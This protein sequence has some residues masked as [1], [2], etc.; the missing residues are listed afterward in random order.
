MRNMVKIFMAR[1]QAQSLRDYLS[2]ASLEGLD[3]EG[4]CKSLED[5]L[6]PSED[7]RRQEAQRICEE[8]DGF[9]CCN[10]DNHHWFIQ[11]IVGC[12]VATI[13]QMNL[14][15][16]IKLYDKNGHNVA[17]VDALLEDEI[18]ASID[19]LGVAYDSQYLWSYLDD[20]ERPG[21]FDNK[22]RSFEGVGLAISFN[23]N[24][25]RLCALL[26]KGYE[27]A[28]YNE[29]NVIFK[30]VA[31]SCAAVIYEDDGEYSIEFLQAFGKEKSGVYLTHVPAISVGYLVDR[32]PRYM[33]PDGC[34]M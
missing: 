34:V 23:R 16:T 8:V 7:R 18:P 30:E 17:V 25:N 3:V 10:D 26:G 24:L 29:R 13:E 6:F 14:C 1:P 5:A 20:G 4:I 32:L 28:S 15:W 31:N 21:S 22:G 2:G 19:I 11:V 27:L 12:H 9:L 33:Y